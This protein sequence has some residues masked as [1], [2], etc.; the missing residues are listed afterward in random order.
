M[1]RVV[2]DVRGR[3]QGVFFR[4]N[5]KE[6]ADKLGLTGRVRNENNGSVRITAEG[7]KR[8]LEELVGWLDGGPAFAKIDRIDVE[9]KEGTGEFNNFEIIY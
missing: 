1:K 5:T 6:K 8:K 7:E 2:I 4:V 9:W 3:V